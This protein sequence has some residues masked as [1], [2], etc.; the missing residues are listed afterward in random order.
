MVQLSFKV[1]EPVKI[2]GPQD[3]AEF[4]RKYYT[5][6]EGQEMFCFLPLDR[7]NKILGVEI[8]SIGGLSETI[9]DPGILFRRFLQYVKAKRLIIAHNHP[10]GN[11]N[12]SDSDIKITNQIVKA[13]KMLDV[14]FN[15]HI[16]LTDKSY[17]SF[18]YQ[19]LV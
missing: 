10:S 15:D 8:L 12:P 6:F 7:E 2:K 11:M 18:R 9:V 3:S 19:G 13:C 5:N 17:Y 16:I 4:L 14:S 1:E